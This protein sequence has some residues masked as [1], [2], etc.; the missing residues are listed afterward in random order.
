MTL[1]LQRNRSAPSLADT[2]NSPRQAAA[3][4]SAAAASAAAASAAAA[5]ASAASA[6]AAASAA[7]GKFF[8]KSGRSGVFLVEDVERPQADVGD[9]FLTE[10]DLRR[11]GIPR[12]YF[13]GR[14]SGC[15]GCAA[16]QRQRHADDSRYRYD[17][18]WIFSLRNTLRLRHSRVLPRLL[19]NIRRS[20]TLLVRFDHAPGKTDYTC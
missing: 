4:A 15:G 6:A 18:L 19:A 13:R 12:G 9:F 1:R 14:H 20:G 16:R 5:A 7:S 8:P 17:F 10:R 11:G 2:A 3:A